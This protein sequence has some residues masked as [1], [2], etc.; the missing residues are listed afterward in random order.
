MIPIL[1]TVAASGGGPTPP[2]HADAVHFDGNAVLARGAKLTGVGDITTFLVSFWIE[3]WSSDGL[4]LITSLPNFL[5]DIYNNP[6]LVGF[7]RNFTGDGSIIYEPTADFSQAI[8]RNVL[9]SGDTVAGTFQFYLTDVVPTP[10]APTTI[11]GAPFT[12]EL[13]TDETDFAVG[14]SNGNNSI[15]DLADVWV[16]LGQYLDLS[17]DANRRKFIDAGGKPVYLG[18]NGE[19]PTGTTPAVF[20]S[21]DAA[22]F[23]T[24]RG[25]GGAFTLTG[26]LTNASTS[27]SD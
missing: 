15:V 12:I 27:P 10:E 4:D 1:G 9:F 3:S 16:G 23:P 6:V 18:A 5:F 8:W 19:L 24:N 7:F 26:A 13:S 14:G 2:Y 22:A 25:T 21:G 20:F 11:Q 17:I